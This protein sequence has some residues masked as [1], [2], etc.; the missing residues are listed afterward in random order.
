MATDQAIMLWKCLEEVGRG[1]HFP[2]AE[3]KDGVAVV[4][5][6]LTSFL[7]I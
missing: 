6:R 5:G 2:R 1:E 3:Q 4:T 7:F